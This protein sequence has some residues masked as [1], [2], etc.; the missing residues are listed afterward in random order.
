VKGE[1]TIDEL[2]AHG[3]QIS[4]P[5]HGYRFSVDPL[6]L[7]DFAGVR[8]GERVIDLGTGCGIM[9][10]FL[11]RSRA[12]VH[13]VG[14]ECQETMAELARRNVKANGLDGRITVLEED[15]VALKRHFPVS[16]FDLVISNP[17]YRRPGTGKVSPRAGRDRARHESTATLAD[18]L[19]V[20]KYLVKPSGRICFIYH[21]S[22]LAELLSEA[23]ALKLAPLRLRMVHGT[24]TA[25]ARMVMVELVKGRGGAVTVLPPLLVYAEQGEY[26]HEMQRIY[27]ERA[28]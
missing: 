5:R 27:G 23:S 26:T 8:A 9:P 16:S 3:L 1:E 11:A 2:S 15:I 18:F 19:S 13:I 24:I 10:L 4:Q 7:C 14:V 12:D 28:C 20:A 6:L 22:R 21:P 17:P 25:E